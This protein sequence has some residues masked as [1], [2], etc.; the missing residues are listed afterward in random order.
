[1]AYAVGGATNAQ[2]AGQAPAY[3]FGDNTLSIEALVRTNDPALRV[4]AQS[5]G[6]GLAAS[7]WTTNDVTAS[8]GAG[9]PGDP[10]GTARRIFSAP[11][12]TNTTKFLRLRVELGP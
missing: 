8:D 2:S 11:I 5:C 4:Y 7:A 9:L 3:G 1:M 12:G 10:Q 6:G